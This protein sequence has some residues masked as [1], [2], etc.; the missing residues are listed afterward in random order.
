MFYRNGAFY[1]ED[2]FVN[3]YTSEI[4]FDAAIDILH[5]TG[6]RCCR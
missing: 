5:K 1:Q 3:I 4:I 6:E 2:A